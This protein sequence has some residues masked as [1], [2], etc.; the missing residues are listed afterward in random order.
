M[1]IYVKFSIHYHMNLWQGKKNE[2]K[3]TSIFFL[4]WQ[5]HNIKSLMYTT[6]TTANRIFFWYS[7]TSLLCISVCLLIFSTF[8]FIRFIY[9]DNNNNKKIG[10][11]IIVCVYKHTIHTCTC[12]H[13]NKQT[14]IILQNVKNSQRINIIESWNHHHTK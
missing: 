2:G 10:I 9:F 4:F 6:T 7:L 12:T 3:K 11:V 8:H 13:T 1:C 14:F 5:C